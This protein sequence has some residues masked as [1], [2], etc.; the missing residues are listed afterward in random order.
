MMPFRQTCYA[1]MAA[2]AIRAESSSGGAFPILAKRILSV[3]GAVCGAAFD[4]RFVCRYEVV[5]DEASL[6]RLKGSK[7]V[8]AA[9]TADFLARV[10]GIL[11]SGRNV[12]FTGTPCQVAAVKRI[13]AAFADSLFTVDLIC[14]GCPGQG[15]FDCYL[16]D[17]WGRGNVLRYE[18]RCKRRG[19]RH[20]HYLL[21]ILLKD[22]R[23]ILREKG[24]DEYM[25]AMSSGLG[26]QDGCL[27]CTFCTMDRPGDLTIGD[28]WQVPK[29]MDDGKGTSAILVNTEKGRRLFESVRP[30]FARVAEY[31]PSMIAERQSRLRTPPTPAVGR[32][33]FWEGIDSGMSVKDAV[34]KALSC[35]DRNVAVLNFH[36]ETVNFGAV[37][38]A[39]ALNRALRD[40]GFEVRNIDF[41]TDL[42]RVA[43]KPPNAKFEAFRRRYIPA[44][45]RIS[46]A[47]GLRRLNALYGSFV[48]GS[49]QVWNPDLTR[50]YGDAYFLSFAD[51]GKRLVAAA[52]SF[53]IDPS[54]AYGMRRLRALLGVFDGL[55]IRE[56]SASRQAAS[57][58]LDV[59]TVADPV[60]L[61]TKEDWGSLAATSSSPGGADV[62][63]Y[64]VNPYGKR[65]L[66]V[67]FAAHSGALEGRLAHLD[68]SMGVEDWL[69]VV[70]KASLVL[71]DSFHGVCFA[72]IFGRPFAVLVSKGPK[73]GRMRDFLSALGL[74]GRI[75]EDPSEMPPVAELERPI[76]FSDAHARIVGMRREL[77]QFLKLSLE[78]P[79]TVDPARVRSRIAAGKS[80]VA[81]QF[82]GL[83]CAWCRA[84]RTFVKL[85]FRHMFG[86]DIAPQVRRLDVLGKEMRGWKN[87]IRRTR[88]A[89][90]EARLWKT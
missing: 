74:S 14:A 81:S 55:G 20:H 66:G 30:A 5:E 33:M 16:D 49:D 44:T 77:A 50:W 32:K 90:K 6:S 26:L 31:P 12:L 27:N 48:V 4:E 35:I 7:Y 9:I 45:Q 10:R 71:T 85:G 29:E 18:F 54:A 37:L 83:F 88:A 51:P 8:K 52:A 3:G 2:D 28:F 61:L 40:M 78:C 23:E 82:G 80:L 25:T 84:F 43:A 87:A 60:F 36:W 75:F 58:G 24:E 89:V 79:V 22:G 42:P 63:W 68:A 70:S 11:E 34:A 76:D 53:G 17:N 69:A 86:R 13:F 72:V 73:S 47:A 38:T 15:L 67:Y 1:A 19:W 65:G 21:R 39:Y 64:A 56:E 57:A 59:K 46:D 62:V 41:R